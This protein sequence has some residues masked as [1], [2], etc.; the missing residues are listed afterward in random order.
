M[1]TLPA[2]EVV[3]EDDLRDACKPGDRVA[4]CGIYKP[5]APRAN[6]SVS[7]GPRLWPPPVAQLNA[8]TGGSSRVFPACRRIAALAVC[9]FVVRLFPQWLLVR[10]ACTCLAHRARLQAC[11]EPW[12]LP[13]ACR[14]CRGMPRAP[15]SA[16]RTTT[17]SRWVVGCECTHKQTG[18]LRGGLTACVSSCPL[19]VVHK[20]LGLPTWP[21]GVG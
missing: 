10:N 13:T 8:C 7:G 21:D 4:I 11:S 1:S 14:S 6:G 3:L 9:C 5:V 15:P 17:T 18:W 16:R 12:W 19:E 20:E 2:V